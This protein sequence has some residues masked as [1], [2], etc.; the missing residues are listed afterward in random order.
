MPGWRQPGALAEGGPSTDA[1]NGPAVAHPAL[2]L[3]RGVAICIHVNVANQHG[4]L[5]T[6]LAARVVGFED[7][8]DVAVEDTGPGIAPDKRHRVFEAYYSTKPGGTGL[9]LAI[10][11]RLAKALGGE[12]AT[13][14]SWLT[15]R[16][17][18]V[19][20]AR[21]VEVSAAATA[22]GTLYLSVVPE[23]LLID[24]GGRLVLTDF[25]IARALSTIMPDER[26]DV[27]WGSPQYFAPEQARG[28]RKV[29]RREVD[30]RH[31]PA[32][33]RQRQRMLGRIARLQPGLGQWRRRPLRPRSRR[34]GR[35]RRCPSRRRV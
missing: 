9:G 29:D 34:R 25:G 19:T 17:G 30:L 26:A 35:R 24:D 28:Q 5:H 7:Q 31:Q 16:P 8:L 32:A 11:R 23:N 20:L 1:S 22:N 18:P 10:S 13:G 4:Q 14:C 33:A 6:I 21:L 2:V 27:V 3:H 12:T 15:L